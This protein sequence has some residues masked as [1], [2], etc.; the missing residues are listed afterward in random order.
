MAFILHSQL[1]S[2]AA[3]VHT[4][5]TGSFT[6]AAVRMG[7]SKSA[8]GKHVARLE[9]RLGVKLLNRTTRSINLT[10]E[11]ELYYRSCLNVLDELD[12]AES[13][14]A[15]RKKVVSGT[16]RISL[17]VSYGR[18]CVMPALATLC[19]EY[20]ELRLDITFT[21][22]RVDLIEENI[23]LAVRLGDTGNSASLSGRKIATQRSV[24][25]ASPA[26]ISRHGL[27]GSAEELLLHACLGFSRDGRVLPWKV[28][29]ENGRLTLIEPTIR[30]IVSHGEAL[31]D[32]AVSGMGIAFLSTWL[33]GDEIAK[34]QLRII[35]VTTPVYDA[36][37]TALWP[38]SRNLSPRIRAVVDRLY[39]A[40]N[41]ETA[42]TR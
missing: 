37:V 11:G 36:P 10:E 1:L 31:R 22:R 32:A 6:A 19:T 26:Y 27:P 9:Q 12:E 41:E 30:H 13:L 23:D 17:P 3:F 33:A 21:D 20:P 42:R 35:P 8:T 5:E 39:A 28:L 16:L 29:D 7:V 18:I 25:C 38:V 15:S 34:G 40:F 14:L 4:V 24:I 2:M